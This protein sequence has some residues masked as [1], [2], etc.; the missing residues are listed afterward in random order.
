MPCRL[1]KIS[2]LNRP[3]FSGRTS[4]IQKVSHSLR[5][6]YRHILSKP[7]SLTTISLTKM[8]SLIS[9][10]VVLL[11]SAVFTVDGKLRGV[12]TTVGNTNFDDLKRRVQNPKLRDDIRGKTVREL[13]GDAAPPLTEKKGS[14]KEDRSL[15]VTESWAGRTLQFFTVSVVVSLHL[16]TTGGCHDEA[17]SLLCKMTITFSNFLLTFRYTMSLVLQ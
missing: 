17:R 8:N 7:S 2:T 5:R 6:G 3:S 12:Q 10:L 13:M 9:L 4:E 16:S 14:V 1:E 15:Q 11:L